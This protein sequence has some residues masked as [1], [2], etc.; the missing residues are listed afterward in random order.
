MTAGPVLATR[1]TEVSVAAVRSFIGKHRRRSW[2]DW[3]VIGFALV[4]AAIYGANFLASPLEPRLHQPAGHAAA[5]SHGGDASGRGGR[6][7]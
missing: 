6:Y 2:V 4:I 3:Y 1:D 5:D 7:W